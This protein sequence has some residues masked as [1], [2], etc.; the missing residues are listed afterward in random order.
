MGSNVDKYVTPTEHA[1]IDHTGLPGIGAGAVVTIVGAEILF[2]DSAPGSGTIY[3]LPTNKITA[4]N[5]ALD[6]VINFTPGTG[7]D[8]GWVV[9][10][11]GQDLLNWATIPVGAA[12]VGFAHI[13]VFRTGATTGR[14]TTHAWT[15][16]DGTPQAGFS[17][18]YSNDAS[19]LTLDWAT[20]LALT[21]VFTGGTSEDVSNV[22]I[23]KL[24]EAGALGVSGIGSDTLPVGVIVPFGG[25]IASVPV[26]FLPC[27]G[28]LADETIEVELFGVIGST[29]NIGGEP[30]G[31]FRLPDLR[32]KSLLGLNDGTLP[33]GED[34]GFATRTLAAIGGEEDNTLTIA[35]LP[36]HS[37]GTSASA[38]FTSG[39]TRVTGTT[40]AETSTINTGTTGSDTAHNT[41]HPFAVC[42]YIIKS[43][44]VGGGIGTTAQN[45]AGAL[46]GPQPTLNFVPSG[47]IGLA[48]VEDVG[49]NRINITI[50][51]FET[52]TSAVHASTNHAGIPGV[53][54]G[55]VVQ[56]KRAIRQTFLS[57]PTLI[58]FD[59]SIPQITE[60][61]EVL[62]AAITPLNAS[63]II[64]IEFS[65]ELATPAAGAAISAIFQDSIANA[66]AASAMAS[67]VGLSNVHVRH[68]LTAGS[69]S[70]RTYRVRCGANNGASEINGT[71]GAQWALGR[72]ATVLTVTEMT[73]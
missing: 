46:Q 72:A 3:T 20:S 12:T 58:P 35:E 43:Q 50:S 44:Q 22:H 14:V 11:G 7:T 49:N 42:S 24:P 60:G 29:W 37:H 69:T 41:M 64:L 59:N 54:S 21:S 5:Q 71:G 2:A 38:G 8:P 62:T 34:G 48:V 13:R 51:A 53:G 15:N 1:N 18:V 55:I 6:I 52:F 45:N 40:A 31:F 67:Q 16:E 33:A 25:T 28:E 70:A 39:N 66:L 68:Y 23:L 17:E 19:G 26:G 61:T 63:N 10:L 73:P 30:G 56:Q 65:G 57:C 27:D 4:D 47:I 9:Q 36:A 32:G